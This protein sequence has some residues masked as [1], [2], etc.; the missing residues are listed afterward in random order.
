MTDP[1]DEKGSQ[2][3]ARFGIGIRPLRD[4]ERKEM[5]FDQPGGVIVTAVEDGSFADEIGV[6]ERDIVVSIN[7][8]PV[9]SFD[10]VKRIQGTLKPGASVA[11]KIMR[12]VPNATKRGQT[13]WTGTY[14]SGELPMQ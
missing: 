4:E 3:T 1:E 11:F 5:Q 7:R 12:A 13:T 2:T 9:A 10:D 8:Q 6:R 14:L